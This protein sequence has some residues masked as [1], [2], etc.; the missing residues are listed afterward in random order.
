MDTSIACS[1][2][3]GG[4]KDRVAWIADLNRVA[5]RSHQRDDLVLHLRYDAKSADRVIEMVAS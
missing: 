4:F 2:D 5:L 1:L 3:I